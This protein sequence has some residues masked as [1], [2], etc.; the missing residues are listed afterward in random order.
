M[1]D[2]NEHTFHLLEQL[3][4]HLSDESI[5]DLILWVECESYEQEI[6]SIKYETTTDN[7]QRK[8]GHI[9]FQFKEIQ[10][11]ELLNIPF[12]EIKDTVKDGLGRTVGVYYND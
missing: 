8:I 11:N 7:N 6:D 10:D 12:D 1:T 5:D 3:K 9:R 2:L 4:H